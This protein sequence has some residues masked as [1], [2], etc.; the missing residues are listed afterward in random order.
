MDHGYHPII[1]PSA[2]LL[3][4]GAAASGHS[5]PVSGMVDSHCPV[6]VA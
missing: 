6:L 5:G 4:Y 3:E 2:N 1:H